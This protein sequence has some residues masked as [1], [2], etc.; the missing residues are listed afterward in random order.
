MVVIVV[1][2][3]KLVSVKV[4]VGVD[5]IVEVPGVSKQ[6]HTVETTEFASA[7]KLL[8]FDAAV[9]FDVIEVVDTF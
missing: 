4:D 1:V 7:R 9:S 6:E 3:T 5:V 8:S 2:A